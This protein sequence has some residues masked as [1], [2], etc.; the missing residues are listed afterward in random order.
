ME[1][2]NPITLTIEAGHAKITLNRPERLNALTRNMLIAAKNSILTA[3]THEKVRV[4]LLTGAGRGFCAGQDLSERDPRKL[5]AP[6]DLEAIQHELFHPIVSAL[7][8]K[9]KP[10]V[11]AVNGVAAGAG[12]GLAMA[13]DIV[14]A[15]E[16][17]KFAFSFAKVGLSVDAGLG[18]ALTLRIGMA[19]ATALLMLGEDMTAIEAE[20]IGLIW[21]TV[22]TTRLEDETI[23]LVEKL[24]RTPSASLAGIKASLSASSLPLQDYLKIEAKQQG[25]AGAHPDYAEGVLAFLERRAPIFS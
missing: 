12:L 15:T 1:L 4:I 18:R 5:S 9:P 21:R 7:Q 10:V 6:L 19:R 11:S 14:I 13:A 25:I 22:P 17:A 16:D 23:A 24:S 20:K 8:N 3:I 2:E